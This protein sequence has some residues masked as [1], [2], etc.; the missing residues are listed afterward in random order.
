M[1]EAYA[2]ELAPRA[3]AYVVVGAVLGT[4]AAA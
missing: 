4:I 1:P 3:V 2:M